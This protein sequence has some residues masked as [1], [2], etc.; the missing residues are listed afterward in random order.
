MGYHPDDV[1][2]YRCQTCKVEYGGKKFDDIQLSH[3]KHHGRAKLECKQ[4]VKDVVEKV[5]WLQG[6]LKGS[7]V[8]CNCGCPIHREK[9]P[10]TPVYYGHRRWPGSDGHISEEDRDFLNGLNPQPD[11]WKKAWRKGA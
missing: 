11:W 6:R 3:H 5:K 4:C 2:A 9:C 1:N 7:K 10:L 8:R